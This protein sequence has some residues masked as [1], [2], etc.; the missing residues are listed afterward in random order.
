MTR[1]RVDHERAPEIPAWGVLHD[2]G[3]PLGN[4]SDNK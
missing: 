3:G 4:S 1:P 2:A